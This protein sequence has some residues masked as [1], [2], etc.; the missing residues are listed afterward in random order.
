MIIDPRCAF[1]QQADETVGHLFFQCGF[2]SAVWA[3]IRHWLNLHYGMTTLLTSMKWLKREHRGASVLVKART[4]AFVSTVYLLWK[5][6]NFVILE[7]EQ[8]DVE[9]LV[10]KIKTFLYR[11]LYMIFPPSMVIL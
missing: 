9:E 3:R 11:F 4:L 2:T 5:A 1:C 8:V 7:G 6:R 10:A